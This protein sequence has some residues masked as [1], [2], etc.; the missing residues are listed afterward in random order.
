MMMSV[1]GRCI[2]RVKLRIGMSESAAQQE[3][4]INRILGVCDD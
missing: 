2:L 3:K 1:E 4:I